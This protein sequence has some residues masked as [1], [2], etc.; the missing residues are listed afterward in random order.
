MPANWIII[1]LGN[2]FR[3]DDGVGLLVA[4]QIQEAQLPQVTVKEQSGEGA[5]LIDSWKTY[6]KVVLVDAVS[7]GAIPGTVVRI[8]ARVENI[9]TK[10]FRYSTHAFGLAEAVE[11]TRAL[12]AMPQELIVYGIEGKDF[13]SGTTISPLVQEAALKLSQK[14]ISD[15]KNER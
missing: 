9:P 5:A 6:E 3:N 11:L 7:S 8:D 4:R 13:D 2:E 10:F 14:I 15:I 12:D 1:G